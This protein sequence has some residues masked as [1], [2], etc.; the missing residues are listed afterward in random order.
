MQ[1]AVKHHLHSDD[2][3]RSLKNPDISLGILKKYL[4]DC[5]ST[6]KSKLSPD[7]TKFALIVYRVHCEKFA[8]YSP[9]RLLVQEVG[10]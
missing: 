5:M 7:K 4:Q 8:K 3:F 9:T 6:R 2:A 10:A 1:P